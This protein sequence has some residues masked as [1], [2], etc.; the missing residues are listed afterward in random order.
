M[1]ETLFKRTK[2]LSETFS[3]SEIQITTAIGDGH[4]KVMEGLDKRLRETAVSLDSKAENLSR[5]LSE[6]AVNI[7]RTMGTNLV[8]TQR[9][10]EE[11][12]VK[13]GKLLD[14]RSVGISTMLDDRAIKISG[15]L[16]QH[17]GNIFDM[18]SERANMINSGMLA[19]SNEFVEIVET[20]ALPMVESLRRV[21]DEVS[22]RLS[23]TS[24][25]V[26]SSVSD[27]IN[28]LGSS[29]EILRTLV[30]QAGE[31][32]G[33]IQASLAQQSSSL[34]D[35]FDK[36]TTNLELSG[37]LASDVQTGMK[38]TASNLLADV[39]SVAERL[40]EQGNILVEATRIIDASQTNFATTLDVRQ[41]LLKELSNGL[42]Q[43]S[44][45]IEETMSKMATTVTKMLTDSSEKSK[46]I[47]G[48]VSAEVSAAINS[49]TSRFSDATE[50][51]KI[52]ARDVSA[53]L[54]QTREQM[55]RGVLELPNETR[56]SA[57]SMR[58]VVTDQI[59]ALKDLSD[60]VVRSG[61]ALDATPAS[62]SAR[63]KANML[64]E[65][66][67]Q[68][69]IQNPEPQVAAIS[70]QQA[71]PVNPPSRPDTDTDQKLEVVPAAAPAP[72]TEQVVS[73]APQP[74]PTV[75]Q[76]VAP[77]T[78]IQAAPEI[79]PAPQNVPQTGSVFQQP[80]PAPNHQQQTRQDN[81]RSTAGP[82]P[83]AA[84]RPADPAPTQK[85]NGSGGWVSDL[86]RRASNNEPVSPPTP[87]QSNPG[88]NRS[89]HHVV[90]SLNALSMDIARAID[91]EASVELWDRY[92]RG[93]RDVFTRR[94][95]TIQGQK[96]FDEIQKKYQTEPDFQN[97]V[98]RY[99]EDF[100][101]LLTDI[102]RNDRDNI[103]TQTYLTSDTG[104]VYT[105]LAHASG[106]FGS[107]Q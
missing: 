35:A 20:K 100:E 90:E 10:I 7:N 8:E 6:R 16:E 51:M 23:E 3:K 33:T 47:G 12:T 63:N 103:M 92:Q 14:E 24:G 105:M 5:L 34:M 81:I 54:E 60:I 93:E 45:E 1:N 84:A 101:K 83:A 57:D 76:Q 28:K 97:A 13:L 106:R 44:D 95:Y 94:L 39:N 88:A 37:K 38:S 55:R 40:N 21:G 87:P 31:N 86:L 71:K 19:R 68:R 102:A 65:P 29:N 72:T 4:Q 70:V 99:V 91:H 36:A 104:K 46:E 78:N 18:L 53:E 80:A 66:V 59:K 67:A 74:T 17:S 43:R 69:V 11:N 56:Q 107:R 41:E 85:S 25:L 98:N 96:T 82:A 22:H 89:P 26:D 9:T 2:E 42:V 52:A 64:S 49:A 62:R 73:A 79:M 50:S 30:E 75:D 77:A 48:I 27:V 32:L 58:R 61:K 15:V